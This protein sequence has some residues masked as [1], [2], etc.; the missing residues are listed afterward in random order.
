LAGRCSKK[1][2]LNKVSS[3]KS[4]ENLKENGRKTNFSI[5]NQNSKESLNIMKASSNG[6]KR[7][8]NQYE[9]ANK[10]I[11][12]FHKTQLEKNLCQLSCH[13]LSNFTL[14]PKDDGLFGNICK[15]FLNNKYTICFSFCALCKIRTSVWLG[16]S[17]NTIYS[18]FF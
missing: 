7:K 12:H 10:S 4:V 15:T 16:V 18:T 1:L 9:V 17:K 8:S 13:K 5:P 6:Y 14:C 11:R 2:L 3:F